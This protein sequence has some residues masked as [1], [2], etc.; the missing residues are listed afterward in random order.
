MQIF[1]QLRWMT[2]SRAPVT[3]PEEEGSYRPGVAIGRR[4]PGRVG[5]VLCA[6]ALRRHAAH[7]GARAARSADA[8]R[9]GRPA[10]R[11]ARTAAGAVRRVRPAGHRGLAHHQQYLARRARPRPGC[12]RHPAERAPVR[13]VEPRLHLRYRPARRGLRCGGQH[14]LRLSERAVRPQRA[15][16]LGST[17]G[18]G[19]DVDIYAEKLDPP[20]ARATS[21]TA[22]GNA[23][24]NAANSF[25]S[26][27]ASRC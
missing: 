19:D 5:L 17:A 24:R 22:S 8:R 6:A 23:W 7:A 20:T 25:W 14:A 26:R 9:A 16:G 21:T 11:A 15:R 13:L 18:F 10:G 27:A 4:R 1:N 12:A 3:V 2:D